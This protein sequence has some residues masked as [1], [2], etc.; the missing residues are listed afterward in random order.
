MLMAFLHPIRVALFMFWPVWIA[1]TVAAAVCV[2]WF[3]GRTASP[4]A[5]KVSVNLTRTER[6][7][8]LRGPIAALTLLVVFLSGYI[9]MIL[10]WENFAY[11]D[12]SIFTLYT[13]RGHDIGLPIMPS[14]GRFFPLGFQEFNLIRHL[15]DTITG[16]HALRIAQLLI[17]CWVLLVFDEELSI[18]ARAALAA[19]ALITPSI[20]ISF[21]WLIY[22]EANVL[23]CIVCLALFV[24]RFEQ[25]QSVGWAVAAA[26]CAQIM[27]YYKETASLLLL[28][29]AVSRLVLRCRGTDETSRDYSRLWDKESRLDLCLAALAVLFWLY[30][31][32]V[33]F[34]HPD[35]QYADDL[36]QPLAELF[37][38]YIKSD[39]LALLFVGTVLVRTYLIARYRITP[40]LLW[41]G[42]AFGGI[43]CVIGSSS[44]PLACRSS[45]RPSVAITCWRTWSPAR[46]LSTI[47]R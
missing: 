36:R 27:I 35:M 1:M 9:T 29:F 40:S 14:L 10:A 25:N 28:G 7:A 13:L 47:C 5:Q 42:L 19:F 45:K 23:L 39:L 22:H 33:M 44:W 26:V 43:A 6:Q 18:G 17:F 8:G 11:H 15:T 41:D 12:N 46:R 37:L 30:Y 16:Y 4:I 32:G 2:V 3:I 31:L 34:P 21:S 20:L 38:G 24:K